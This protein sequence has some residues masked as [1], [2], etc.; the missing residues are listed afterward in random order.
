MN[1]VTLAAMFVVGLTG[2]L[3]CAGM[4]GPIIWIMPFATFDG[5]RKWFS[6]ILYHF[7]RISVYALFGVVL[8]SFSDVFKPEWQQFISMTLGGVLLIVGI[9]MYVSAKNVNVPW[10]GFVKKNLGK[11]LVNPGLAQLSAAGMLNGLLPCG[12]VYMAL[13]MAVTAPSALMSGMLMYAFGIG[14]LPM[15]IGL[16]I[17]R[18]RTFVHKFM[19]ARK[20][21]P[22]VIFVFGCL[23][24]LRG[25]NLGIPYISPKV[26][27]ENNEV[28]QNCC[29]K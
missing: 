24:M 10:T 21:V 12:L 23:F 3:H 7:A 13:S 18:N 20:A 9:S 4:C 1:T 6:I 29:H 26:A 17:M 15:L 5:V 22:V 28:K 14:T 11:F 8:H 16:T 27:I 2:S 25:L 19:Y